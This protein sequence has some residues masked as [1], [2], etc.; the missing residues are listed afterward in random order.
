[1]GGF[2]KCCKYRFFQSKSEPKLKTCIT[3]FRGTVIT[4]TQGNT[5]LLNINSKG[6]Y[7]KN[8]I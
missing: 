2:Q 1:M 4:V 8:I 7:I 5:S 6:F 3:S